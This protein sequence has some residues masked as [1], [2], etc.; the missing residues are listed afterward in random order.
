MIKNDY[1]YNATV[2]RVVD[3]D[4]IDV[5]IDLGFS[6]TFKTRMRLE[7][8]DA[9]ET[10]DKDP[11]VREMGLKAK[12]FLTDLLTGK[13]VT[14]V[15]HKPDK[16][17]RYLATIYLGGISVNLQLLKEGLAVSYNGGKKVQQ[18]NIPLI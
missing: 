1:L 8:L 9:M 15:S 5:I 4:T 10:N 14:L 12:K 16:Y 11:T 7:G 18:L 2:T 3:G 6:I 17:G 13:E